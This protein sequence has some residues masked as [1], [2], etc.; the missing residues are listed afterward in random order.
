MADDA[1]LIEF[2]IDL[3]AHEIARQAEV[4]L[5]LNDDF[6]EITALEDEQLA[7]R[8][9]YSDLDAE[10][11]AVYDNLVEHGVLPRRSGVPDAG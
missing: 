10:Q 4:R 6:D 8:M 9:L 3:T 5:A 7:Y 1:D 11:Q 2:S